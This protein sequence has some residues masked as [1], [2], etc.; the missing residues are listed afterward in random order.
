[1]RL[2]RR[3]FGALWLALAAAGC[4]SERAGTVEVTIAAAFS[5]RQV[6]PELIAAFGQE[7]PRV[8]IRASYGASG[9][10]E[11]RVVEGA[12]YDAVM[13]ASGKPVASLIA[14]GLVVAE[15]RRTV[16][17]GELVLIAPKRHP[18]ALTFATIDQLPPGEKIA[19]GEP[20]AVPAGEYARQAFE[21]L[22][23]WEAIR[24]QLVLG[25]D[26]GAVLAYARRGEVAVSVVY[27]TEV[28]GLENELVIL[29]RAVG[30]WAPTPEVVVGLVTDGRRRKQAAS[31]LEFL[32][33]EEGAAIF[34]THGFRV[35]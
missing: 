25:G 10:L 11:R 29:D 9:D 21:Q 14:A 4:K 22:G 15:S 27:A 26:V 3:D 5:L 23:K 19:I 6:L 17:R 12:P 1:M 34:R 20:G 2:S 35:D 30:P 8:V 7:H 16:A 33:D 31:F 28:V 13:F 18:R 24:S 32:A